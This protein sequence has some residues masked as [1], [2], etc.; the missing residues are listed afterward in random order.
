MSAHRVPP[1]TV[2]AEGDIPVFTRL[3]IDGKFRKMVRRVV[4]QR[5]SYLPFHSRSHHQPKQ[6]AAKP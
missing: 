6:K 4:D 1:D 5:N 3:V 2:N